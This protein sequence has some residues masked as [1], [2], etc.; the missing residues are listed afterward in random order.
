MN[1]L[2]PAGRHMYCKSSSHLRLLVTF[3]KITVHKLSHSKFLLGQINHFV[4][5][6]ES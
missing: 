5:R 2:A 4:F 6:C 1:Y 3:Q